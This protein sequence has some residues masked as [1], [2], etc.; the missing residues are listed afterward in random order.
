VKSN[1]LPPTKSYSKDRQGQ[2]M[3]KTIVSL[4]AAAAS[5]SCISAFAAPVQ[6]PDAAIDSIIIENGQIYLVADNN[7][8]K[9]EVLL[10]ALE[11]GRL[12]FCTT[13]VTDM[14]RLF[15]EREAFNTDISDWDTSNVT[16]M[17][18]MFKNSKAFNQ[19]LTNWNVN[20]VTNHYQF[21]SGSTLTEEHLP[22]FID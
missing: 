19:D 4:L 2:K 18:T 8:I 21:A 20:E 17:N 12:R 16:H 7:S 9:N 22:H 3:K 13:Q 15:K 6:C 1:E 5:L 11:E 10:Q 14:S